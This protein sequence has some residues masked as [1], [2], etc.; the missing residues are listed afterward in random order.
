MTCGYVCLSVHMTIKFWVIIVSSK[1][2]GFTLSYSHTLEFSWGLFCLHYTSRNNQV[3][4]RG[5][6]LNQTRTEQSAMNGAD[7]VHN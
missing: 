5:I 1:R 4:H 3:S 7:D 6:V 2:A